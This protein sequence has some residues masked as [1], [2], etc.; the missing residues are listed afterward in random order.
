MS[1]RERVC[2]R[3][4]ERECVR[5]SD[6]ERVCV[7]E[8]VCER[9]YPLGLEVGDEVSVVDDDRE[10]VR[11]RHEEPRPASIEDLGLRVDLM[12]NVYL[13]QLLNV[14]CI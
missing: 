6:R 13:S 3:E 11:G 10:R 1:V 4:I 14:Q 8:R 2:E 5:E 9:E 12:F 7:R